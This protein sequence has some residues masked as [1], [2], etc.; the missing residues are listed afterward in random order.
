MNRC[1]SA[2]SAVSVLFLYG[3]LRLQRHLLLSLGYPGVKPDQAFNTA[4]SFVTN[5]NWQSYSGESTMGHLVQMAGLAVQNFASAAVADRLEPSLHVGGGHQAA[6]RRQRVG[7]EADEQLAALDV[8]HRHQQLVAEHQQRG[9]H[10]GQLIERRR[11]EPV[12]GGERPHQE[13]AIGHQPEVVDRRVALV[14]RDRVVAVIAPDLGEAAR[15]QIERGVPRELAP[16]GAV[17]H[18]RAAQAV[19]IV[20]EIGERGALGAHVAARE[21]IV[22]VAAHR[23]HAIGLDGDR[24]PAGGLA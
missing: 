17:A 19:R 22:G 11:R 5:T 13:L 1:W 14:D 12:A 8:G 20:V 16:A 21:R 15:H 18:H 4:A 24:E 7:A 9:E 3:F 10:V 2:F 23:H 6:V